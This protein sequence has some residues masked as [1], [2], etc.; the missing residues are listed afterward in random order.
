M[1]HITGGALGAAVNFV[2]TARSLG[3][4]ATAPGAIWHH[5]A[6]RFIGAL[7]PAVWAFHRSGTGTYLYLKAGMTIQ[8]AVE[9]TRTAVVPI[10]TNHRLC[11]GAA[12]VVPQR[13]KEA[14]EANWAMGITLAHDALVYILCYRYG[15]L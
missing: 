13:S 11:V 9:A 8:A 3:H 7:I 5:A 1:S 6:G 12:A 10:T 4:G 14:G 2:F 15:W